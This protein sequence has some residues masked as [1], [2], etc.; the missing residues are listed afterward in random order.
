VDFLPLLLFAIVMV[1]TPGPANM[2][3]M[4]SGANFGFWRSVPFVSGVALGKLLINALLGLGL[5]EI[6][7]TYSEVLF[8]LKMVS[9]AYLAWLALRMSG[10]LLKK[11]ELKQA[12][13]FWKGLAVHPL[14][15]KA[16]AML[17]FA[18]GHFSVPSQSLLEQTLVISGTFLGVQ[19]VFHSLWCAGGALVVRLLA[20]KPAERWLMRGLSLCTVLIVIWAVALDGSI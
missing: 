13:S 11:R 12:E 20:G 4:T 8:A 9:V 15:P 6:L 14:N 19:I 10:F 7:S 18:Y 5:W 3:L 17:V 16:W 1:G 2:L